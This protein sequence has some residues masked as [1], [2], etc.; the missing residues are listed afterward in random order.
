[1]PAPPT[2]PAPGTTS[3]AER[4]RRLA[5]FERAMELPLVLAA[6][7][8]ILVAFGHRGA[9]VVADVIFVVSW[10]VFLADFVVHLWLSDRYLRSWMGVFDL[11]V[12]ILTTPLFFIPGFA[13]SQYVVVARLGRLLR[14]VLASKAARRLIQQLGRA[15]LVATAMVLLCAYIA[16]E[17]EHSVNPEFLTYADAA[18]W[19]IVTLTT[20]GYG[21]VV[22]ITGIGR[23]AG[24]VLMVTGIGIIGTLAGSLASF[25]RIDRSRATAGP[26]AGGAPPGP[27]SGAPGAPGGGGAER[28]GAERGMAER[29]VALQ[30]QVASLSAELAELASAVSTP[31]GSS[32]PAEPAA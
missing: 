3:P 7:L 23:W 13:T 19:G 2:A 16:Y 18:W 21:D 5:S 11:V 6:L 24:V 12:V 4:A 29:V 14:L 26:G 30:A 32:G 22:P 25:L 20:V 9:S 17:A 8:P 31:E 28:G 27:P 10:L 15:A 1:M